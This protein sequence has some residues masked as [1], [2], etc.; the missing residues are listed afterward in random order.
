MMS[1]RCSRTTRSPTIQ[2]MVV[3]SVKDMTIRRPDLKLQKSGA[4]RWYLELD[5]GLFLDVKFASPLATFI[6]QTWWAARWEA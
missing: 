4:G 6:P 1:D 5:R 2:A 3:P